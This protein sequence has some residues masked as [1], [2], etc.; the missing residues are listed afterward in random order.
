LIGLENDRIRT[1]GSAFAVPHISTTFASH[2]IVAIY[3][4]LLRFGF[5]LSLMKILLA[6]YSVFN[7]P[8]LA[9]EGEAMLNTL[10]GSFERCGYQVCMPKVG[11]FRDELLALAP[12]CDCGLVIAPDQLLSGYTKIIEDYSRNIGCSS[13]TVAIC[14]NKKITAKILSAHGIAVPEEVTE[15]LKVIKEISGCG[16]Q[17]MRISEDE[18]GEGEFGQ[19]L[20][21][22]DPAYDHVSVS[23]VAGRVVGEACLYAT[24]APPVV[25]ALNRQH[26]SIQN[27]RIQFMGVETPASHRRQ[28]EII[29][30]AKRAATVLGCQGYVGI[31]IVVGDNIYVVDVNPRITSSI[32]AISVVMEEEIADILI[33]ASYGQLPDAV[34][35][36]GHVLFDKEGRIVRL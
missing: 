5:N 23:L 33:N 20:I 18:P 4:A 16:T 2:L 28:D 14:A 24:D 13:L 11:D 34:H 1:S 19:R 30:T 3:M 9:P 31:D 8:V 21:E 32:A 26:I 15:G 22:C 6:E 29:D 35:L 10:K 12:S 25:L 7:D 17:N 27:G 36:S